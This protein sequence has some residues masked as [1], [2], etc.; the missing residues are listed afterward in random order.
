MKIALAETEADIARCYPVMVELRPHLKAAEFTARVRKQQATGFYLAYLEDAGEVRA[1]SGFRYL[2]T[3]AWGKILYVDDLVA[4]PA[5]RSR[6][7][8]GQLFDWLVAQAKQNNC[9]ELHL[10]SG[11]QRFG[12]HRF[13]LA[14]RMDINCHH[15]ALKLK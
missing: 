5:Q 2:E 15:F 1:V 4:D 9:D 11:V 6:G 13:Y 14:R 12:A 8:G 7:Y 10:D 3:L